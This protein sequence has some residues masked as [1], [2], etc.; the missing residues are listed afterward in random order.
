M[1]APGVDRPG[2]TAAN[3]GRVPGSRHADTVRLCAP[4]LQLVRRLEFPSIIARPMIIATMSRTLEQVYQDLHRRELHARDELSATYPMITEAAVAAMNQSTGSPA[5]VRR[6]LQEGRIFSVRHQGEDR[7]PAYQFENGV[8][9]RV[10]AKILE[11]LS[12]TDPAARSNPDREPPY[13]EWATAFWFAGANGWLEAKA[14]VELMELDPMAVV[15]AASH[16]CDKI[17]D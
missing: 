7:Y 1:V 2:Y 11:H 15:T 13:S 5:T 9:K 10:I 16:A 6:W 12:P 3:V 4:R 17:S 14:P 8:P